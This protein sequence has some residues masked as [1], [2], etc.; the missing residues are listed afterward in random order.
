MK[1]NASKVDMTSGPLLS[2]IILFALPLAAGSI[3]QQLF[4]AVDIAVVGRFASSTALA[5]VGANAPVISLLVNFFVG[6]AVGCTVLVANY[7]GGGT[8]D[9]IPHIIHTAVGMS[10]IIGFSLLIIGIAISRPILTLLST[11][12]NAL[13]DAVL[14]LRI[15]CLGMPFIMLYNFLN[16]IFRSIGDT[17][18]PL[19]IL[20]A[21]GVVNA[22]L[23]LFF[24]IVC[25]MGVEGVAIATVISNV[26]SSLTMLFLLIKEEEPLRFHPKK[27]HI[28]R[29]E[30]LNILKIGV[31]AGIQGSVFS[32]SN[33]CVQSSLNTF[34]SDAVAAGS[35]GVTMEMIAFFVLSGF[36]QAATTFTAQ[37]YGAMKPDRCRR[38]YRLS[39]ACGFIACVCYDIIV[40]LARYPLI[41]LFTSDPSVAALA[42]TRII[43]LLCAQP[44]VSIYEV[45]GASLRGMGRSLTPAV[46]TVI[47]T[48]V[49][50]VIWVFTVMKFRHT[51]ETLLSVYGLSWLLTGTIMVCAYI[52]FSRKIFRGMESSGRSIPAEAE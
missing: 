16:A 14:Y 18:R 48:C 45:S 17:K 32:I 41:S 23:N 1:K 35:V 36:T 43:M 51:Y 34:G 2:K 29:N 24:V 27:T 11:P 47:G 22:C 26:I 46:I 31:P 49:L 6:T 52:Y 25:G 33:V 28:Y 37:N 4:N 19:Y 10:L 38:V 12:E 21:A 3:L 8:E 13:D 9:R 50:R 15:Y 5:A 7:I 44:L 20:A 42:S 39:A 30:L 40:I